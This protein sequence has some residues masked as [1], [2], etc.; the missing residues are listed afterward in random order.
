MTRLWALV[1]AFLLPWMG[2]MPVPPSPDSTTA[3]TAP[4]HSELYIPGLDVEDVIIY[5]NEV[6][7]SSE[8]VNSGDPSVVQKWTAPILY[9]L[10]GN[11]T[12]E[13]VQVIEE[14]AQWL[15]GVY[16][17]AG[18]YESPSPEQATLNIYFCPQSEIPERMGP[19]FAYMDGAVTFWY[20][21]NEIYNGVICCRDDVSQYL[22]NSVI[23]EEIYNGLGP[24]Q[25][26]ALRSDSI[27]YGEFTTPQ[28]LSPI[29]ELILKLLYHPSLSCGM[30]AEEAAAAIRE[31]YY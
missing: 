2:A 30:T 23:L 4:L 29:D 27:I 31:L 5:F 12:P 18:I 16:G 3:P 11:Y 6:C 28:A 25:D 19:Q 9:T 13:D 15:N 26:T 14:F 8:F 24:I 22:R 1:I 21:Y 17:F 10:H 20:E 7:L